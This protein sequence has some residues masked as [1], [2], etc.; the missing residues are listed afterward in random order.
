VGAHKN[1]NKNMKNYSRLTSVTLD[2]IIL[3]HGWTSMGTDEK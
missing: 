1:G 2:P 3:N